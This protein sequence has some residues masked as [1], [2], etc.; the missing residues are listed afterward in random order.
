[1]AT[2]EIKSINNDSI[3]ISVMANEQE[4]CGEKYNSNWIHV[5]IEFNSKGFVGKVAA[6]MQTFEF[7]EFYMQLKKLYESLQGQAKLETIEGQIGL[8]FVGNGRGGITLSG[9]IMDKPGIGNELIFNMNLDQS[10]IPSVLSQLQ[11]LNTEF[12]IR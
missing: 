6:H 7:G 4:S 11:S 2:V 3:K 1:M 9:M 10:Y 12:S 5:L 8:T